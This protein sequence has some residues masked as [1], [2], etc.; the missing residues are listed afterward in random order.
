MELMRVSVRSIN[1]CGGEQLAVARVTATSARKV[2][3]GPVA[4]IEMKVAV[5]A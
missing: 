5:E 4:R 3:G 2:N 1:V